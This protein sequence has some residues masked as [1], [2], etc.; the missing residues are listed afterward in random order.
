MAQ[1]ALRVWVSAGVGGN[2]VPATSRL[3]QYP[4]EILNNLSTEDF[5][6]YSESSNQK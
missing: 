1:N 2:F 3:R 4:I 5:N 6:K